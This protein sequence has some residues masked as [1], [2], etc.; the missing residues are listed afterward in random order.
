MGEVVFHRR[1]AVPNCPAMGENGDIF[2]RHPTT[3]EVFCPQHAGDLPKTE[4]PLKRGIETQRRE[5]VEPTARAKADWARNNRQLA[6]SVMSEEA[7]ER[8]DD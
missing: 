6:A 3:G 7:V 1:C 4:K 8:K 2:Y 5:V